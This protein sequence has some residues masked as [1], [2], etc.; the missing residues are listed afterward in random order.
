V[1]ILI[2]RERD[3]TAQ[4][5]GAVEDVIAV[6]GSLVKGDITWEDAWGKLKEYDGVQAV[7]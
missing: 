7:D 5:I 3:T 4:L 1:L 2:F 6:V